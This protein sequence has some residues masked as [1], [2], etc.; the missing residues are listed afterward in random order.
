MIVDINN[1]SYEITWFSRN[2]YPIEHMDKR[3]I[4]ML[5]L[6]K[7]VLIN[8]LDNIGPIDSIVILD[9]ELLPWSA[10]GKS[11]IDNTF[12]SISSLYGKQVDSLHT[13]GYNE[14]LS[15]LHIRMAPHINKSRQDIESEGLVD[16]DTWLA[17][18]NNIS[19]LNSAYDMRQGLDTFNDQLAIYAK[20]TTPSFTAFQVLLRDDDVL[21]YDN[22]IYNTL[23]PNDEPCLVLDLNQDDDTLIQAYEDYVNR[24][25]DRYGPIEGT[26][27]KPLVVN[28]EGPIA[29]YIKHRCEAYLHLVYGPFYKETGTYE[30]LRKTKRIKSKLRSS[31]KEW[32]LGIRLLGMDTTSLEYVNTI[33]YFIQEEGRVAALDPRL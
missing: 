16:V 11:L 25:R 32:E 10:L 3:G 22:D 5:S 2:G 19:Q 15:E 24:L 23:N 21:P 4:D 29:P 13:Y 12:Y 27:I 30:Y 26:V 6:S 7:G 9:G 31:I 20:D 8:Y 18:Q 1:I 14:A 17:Y 33:G 28:K